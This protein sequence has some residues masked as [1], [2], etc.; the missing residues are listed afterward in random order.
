MVYGRR[1][2]CQRP[3]QCYWRLVS[4][5]VRFNNVKL[6]WTASQCVPPFHLYAPAPSATASLGTHAIALFHWRV[7]TSITSARLPSRCTYILPLLRTCTRQSPARCN[8]VYR[9]VC[10][11]TS[12]G[13]PTP[14]PCPIAFYATHWQLGM[15]SDRRQAATRTRLHTP[16][17]LLTRSSHTWCLG[18]RVRDVRCTKMTGDGGRETTRH[19][20]RDHFSH[21]E[22]A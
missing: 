8:T 13:T 11:H 9:E 5:H 2:R 3:S 1:K 19:S 4:R 22:K 14:H 15:S 17:A 21:R 6:P 18:A 16:S 12:V 10:I 20:T 7:S